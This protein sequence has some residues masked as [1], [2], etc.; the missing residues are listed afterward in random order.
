MME[1][2]SESEELTLLVSEETRDLRDEAD[3][4]KRFAKAWLYATFPLSI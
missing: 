3:V 4:D 2:S 1:L